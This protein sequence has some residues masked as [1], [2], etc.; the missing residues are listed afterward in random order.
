ALLAEQLAK[1][2]AFVGEIQAMAKSGVGTFLEIGPGSV[3]TKLT[4]AILAD[5]NTPGEAFALD[6]SGG[7]RPG[8]LDLGH[9]L[10]R[11]AA[12][13]HRVDLTAWEKGSRC[14]PAP[15][16]DRRRLTV[17]LTGANYVNPRTPRPPAVTV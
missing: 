8:V 3:L 5:G 16:A 9:A 2:V 6:A 10:A 14:R 15:A 4:E 7:K 11:L 13:G 17:L 1:P 12:R